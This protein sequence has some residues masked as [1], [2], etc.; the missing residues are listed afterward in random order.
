MRPDLKLLV[1]WNYANE[2]AINAYRTDQ[3]VADGRCEVC[4]HKRGA[5]NGRALNGR[6]C[7][8]HKATP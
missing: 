3:L 2:R 1:R 7:R 5:G 6:R 8:R 4:G